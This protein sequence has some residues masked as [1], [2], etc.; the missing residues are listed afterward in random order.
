MSKRSAARAEKPCPALGVGISYSAAIEPLLEQ[1]PDLCDLI[2]IEPQTTWFETRGSPEPYRIAAEVLEH[3]A[4]LP[5]R[6]LVHSVGVPVGGTIRP[7]PAQ[8]ALLRRTVERFD[9]PWI[10]EHLSFNATLAFKTGFLLPPCQTLEGVE[11]AARAIR[12][13]QTALQVPVAVET[14]VNYLRPRRD[15][16]PDGAFVA[17]VVETAD[18]GILLDLHNIFA[19]SLN[20]R[21][22]VEAFLAQLPLDRVWEIHLAGGFEL[23]GFWLDAH[24]GAIPETLFEIAKQVVPALPNLKAMIFEIFP[25]FVPL[26]GLETIRKQIEKLHELWALRGQVRQERR[27]MRRGQHPVLNEKHVR[28]SP[29]AWEG[30]LGALAIGRPPTDDIARVLTADPGIRIINRLIRE[31]RASMLVRVLRLTARLMM[32]ALGVDVFRVI[33]ADFWSKTPPQQF[34]SSEAEAFAVYLEALD[35]KVPQLA[36]VLE[37]ERAVLAT[38]LDERPRIVAF[39]SDPLPLFRALTEGHLPDVPGQLGHFE[40]EVTPDGPSGATGLD[41]GAMQQTFLPH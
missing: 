13:L 18:C 40:I 30:A 35:L 23:E 21:P 34:A 4:Q 5:G 15:E 6:K 41:I 12:E 10:S 26:V 25:S 3:I 24:S 28:V 32:L 33:L 11:T 7:H 22:S 8:V 2:E 20:G 14:G 39:D 31:F 36:K 19:N 37:F 38:L 9:T 29:A 1:H 16:L 27:S 17:A